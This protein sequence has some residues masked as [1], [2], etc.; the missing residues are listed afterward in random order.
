MTHIRTETLTN[1]LPKTKSP[2]SDIHNN[3]LPMNGRGFCGLMN[4]RKFHQGLDRKYRKKAKANDDNINQHLNQR[5]IG[6]TNS[7]QIPLN[8][9][10]IDAILILMTQY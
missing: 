10:L 7:K 1:L 3:A 5:K 2:F 8:R 6:D 9:A 4:C